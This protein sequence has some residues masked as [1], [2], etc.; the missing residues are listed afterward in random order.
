MQP[1]Q[2]VT[3]WRQMIDSTALTHVINECMKKSQHR[4]AML[5]LD[6]NDQVIQLAKQIW[7]STDGALEMNDQLEILRL[8]PK[9]GLCS[10]ST[11]RRS[12][13]I[14]SQCLHGE[15][16]TCHLRHTMF[17]CHHSIVAS[18]QE[19]LRIL[20]TRTGPSLPFI[21]IDLKLTSRQVSMLMNGPK[22]IIT[23]QSRFSR[24][25]IDELVKKDNEM[26]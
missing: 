1:Q 4:I 20:K 12:D 11:A 8:P 18:F 15:R 19:Q 17:Q 23:C 10:Q 5:K 2:N 16:S 24:K 13:H 26:I 22:Y 14:A 9:D 3:Q 25:T 21:D 6:W 7:Q